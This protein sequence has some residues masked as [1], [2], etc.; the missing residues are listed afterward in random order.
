LVIRSAALLEAVNWSRQARKAGL[1][2]VRLTDMGCVDRKRRDG[3]C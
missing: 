2:F 1:S 3:R